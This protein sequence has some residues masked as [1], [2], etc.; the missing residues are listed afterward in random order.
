MT[1]QLKRITQTFT[2][3]P[4]KRKNDKDEKKDKFMTTPLPF[5]GALLDLAENERSAT[6]LKAFTDHQNA[7]AFIFHHGDVLMQKDGTPAIVAPN[8]VIGK[9]LYDP[10]P[11]FLG[12]DG[13]TPIFAFSFAKPQEALDLVPGSSFQPLRALAMKADAKELAIIGKAK[14]L[15]DWHRFHQ[16]CAACGAKSGGQFGGIK[17]QCPSCSTDHFPRVNPVVIMLIIKGDKC[18]LGRSPGWPDSAFSALAGFVSPGE[19]LEE[20]CARECK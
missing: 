6:Q 16:F 10:G 4:L 3:A 5:A 11:I 9:H 2:L 13:K 7:K 20:A 12:L 19:S 1:R 18:L 8:K 17:R 14:S 15:I